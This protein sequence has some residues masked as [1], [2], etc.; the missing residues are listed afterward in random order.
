MKLQQNLKWLNKDSEELPCLLSPN[1]EQVG[2]LGK[3][4]EIYSCASYIKN[5][6]PSLKGGLIIIKVL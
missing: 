1:K 2:R 5:K 3:E 4:L 6:K